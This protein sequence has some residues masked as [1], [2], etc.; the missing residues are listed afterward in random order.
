MLITV[1]TLRQLYRACVAVRNWWR[2]IQEPF[3]VGD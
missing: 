1:L 3:D 2:E